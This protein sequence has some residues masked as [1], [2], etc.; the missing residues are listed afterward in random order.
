M[1]LF[2]AWRTLN[3][4]NIRSQH[5]KMNF[6]TLIN[7]IL[8][9]CIKKTQ[10]NAVGIS[11]QVLF[12]KGKKVMTLKYHKATG[13]RFLCVESQ[14]IRNLFGPHP[15]YRVKSWSSLQAVKNHALSTRDSNSEIAGAVHGINGLVV[16]NTCIHEW[17]LNTSILTFDLIMYL[18]MIGR[19]DFLFVTKLGHWPKLT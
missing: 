16:P 2:S 17:N 13:L 4:S 6:K 15:I 19:I 5:F 18:L 9:F 3:L 8:D 10:M 7:L 14:G 11:W 12:L 1:S